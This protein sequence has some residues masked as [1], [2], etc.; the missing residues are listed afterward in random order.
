MITYPTNDEWVRNTKTG[1]LGK[2]VCRYNRTND[3]RAVVEVI[4]VGQ[5][6]NAHWRAA[7]AEAA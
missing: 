3:G 5:M 1:T 2:V 7:H 6:K 4:A